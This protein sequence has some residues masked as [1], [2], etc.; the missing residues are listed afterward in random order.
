MGTIKKGWAIASSTERPAIFNDG[1][2]LEIKSIFRTIQGEGPFVDV[3]AVFIRLG[4]C[5]LACN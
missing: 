3:P 5:K 1:T 2:N 4:G